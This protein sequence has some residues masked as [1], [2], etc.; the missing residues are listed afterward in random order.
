ETYNQENRTSGSGNFLAALHPCNRQPSSSPDEAPANTVETGAMAF[1]TSSAEN[2]DATPRRSLKLVRTNK[3]HDDSS[4][5]QHSHLL[6]PFAARPAQ[7]EPEC[8]RE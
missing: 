7:V 4:T 3:C 6:Y 8:S 5:D 2:P 1:R